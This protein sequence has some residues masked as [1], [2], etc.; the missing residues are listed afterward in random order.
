MPYHRAVRDL[1]TW[2]LPTPQEVDIC[3]DKLVTVSLVTYKRDIDGREVLAGRRRLRHSS[4][5]FC[6]LQL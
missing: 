4:E 3:D 6:C 5:H 1:G 2:R